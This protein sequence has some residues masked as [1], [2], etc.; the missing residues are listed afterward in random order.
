MTEQPLNCL[1]QRFP[2]RLSCLP[3]LPLL[4]FPFPSIPVRW[5]SHLLS[6]CYHDAISQFTTLLQGQLCPL[7]IIPLENVTRV[8][9]WSQT[10]WVQNPGLSFTSHGTLGSSFNISMS[11]FPHLQNGT[12]NGMTSGYSHD[13]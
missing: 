10:S 9:L 4:C 7:G 6:R 5:V 2:P 8:L 11:L 3:S 13:E 1:L 12:S